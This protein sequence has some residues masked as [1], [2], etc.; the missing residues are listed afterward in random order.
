MDKKLK[1]ACAELLL[2]IITTPTKHLMKEV[3]DQD[4]KD[5]Q[6]LLKEIDTFKAI[7]RKNKDIKIKEIIIELTQ[8]LEET[9]GR[10][11]RIKE[12]INEK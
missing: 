3:K 9:N 6:E 4:L 11:D 1:K 12:A 2:E 10:I 8:E 5:K 7:Y